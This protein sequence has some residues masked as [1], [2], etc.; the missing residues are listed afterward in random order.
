MKLTTRQVA[1]TGVLGAVIVLLSVTPLGFIPWLAGASLTVM[2]VPVIVGALLEGPLVGLVLGLIF[3]ITSLIQAAVAP[4]GPSDVWFTNPL[5]SVAPRLLIGP[6]AWMAH[7]FVSRVSATAALA[8]GALAGSLA[9]TILVLGA[10]GLY[11]F[12]PWA[13]IATIAATNGLPEAV[14]AAVITVAVVK[15]W[16]RAE[17]DGRGSSL[18]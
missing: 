10:L 9:N 5:V 13:L 12:L 15:A 7:R 2:H 18:Q 11:G 6:A 8:V 1:V 17:S 3:G 4:R 14:A 16:T